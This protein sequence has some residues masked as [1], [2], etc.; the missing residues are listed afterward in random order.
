M[1]IT[2]LNQFQFL[3]TAA[4][5]QWARAF[6]QQAEGW[7]FESQLRQTQVV[8]TGSDSSTAKRAAIGGNVRGPQR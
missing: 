5:A 6:T 3:I 2:C 8:N 7:V 4:V 1:L